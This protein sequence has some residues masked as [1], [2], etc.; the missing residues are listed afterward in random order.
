MSKN[1]GEGG[2][3]EERKSEGERES[4][5]MMSQKRALVDR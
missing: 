2:R 3:E 4:D 5:A 1:E